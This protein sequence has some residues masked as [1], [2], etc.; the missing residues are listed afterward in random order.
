MKISNCNVLP[1]NEGLVMLGT[2]EGQLVLLIT[3]GSPGAVLD[4]AEWLHSDARY[5][6]FGSWALL[7]RSGFPGY[8]AVRI[9]NGDL[10]T[11]GRPIGQVTEVIIGPQQVVRYTRANSYLRFGKNNGGRV[12]FGERDR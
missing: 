9:G 1:G 6:Y 5:R 12:I 11:I 8:D 7:R 10:L 4:A 3:G 2:Y